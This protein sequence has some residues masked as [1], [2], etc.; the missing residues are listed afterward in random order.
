M[1]DRLETGGKLKPAAKGIPRH[2]RIVE[3]RTH[4]GEKFESPA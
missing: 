2:G 3:I 1:G 4:R